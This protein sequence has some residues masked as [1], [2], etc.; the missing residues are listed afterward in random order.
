MTRARGHGRRPA[1]VLCAALCAL[2]LF[3][4]ACGRKAKPQPLWSRAAP[5]AFHDAAR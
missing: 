2:A 1:A 3:A 5:A 4:P